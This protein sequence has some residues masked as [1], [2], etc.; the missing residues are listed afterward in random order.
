MKT[1]SVYWMTEGAELYCGDSFPF[2][3]NL[4]RN[5]E[6]I[7]AFF[8]LEIGMLTFSKTSVEL[9]RNSKNG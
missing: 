3:E 8:F 4:L 1:L 7:P 5:N 6:N 9:R 2:L